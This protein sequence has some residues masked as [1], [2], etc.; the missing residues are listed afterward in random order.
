MDLSLRDGCRLRVRVIGRGKPVILLHGFGLNANQWLPHA[1]SCSTSHSFIIPDSRGHGTSKFRLGQESSP[2]ET[3]VCDLDEIIKQLDVRDFKLCGYSMGAIVGLAYT[4]TVRNPHQNS[5]LHIE[6][7]PKFH[8]D[9]DWSYGFNPQAIAKAVELLHLL[10]QEVDLGSSLHD[11]PK[12]FVRAYRE[13][14]WLLARIAFPPGLMRRLMQG[15]PDLLCQPWLPDWQ[16]T[17]RLFRW[18]LDEGFDLTSHLPEIPIPVHLVAAKQS[19]YFPVQSIKY[20]RERIKHSK[21]TVFHESGHGLMVSEPIKF[22]RTFR[23]FVRA[24]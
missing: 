20:M 2:L 4:S 5:Y 15:A 6:A 3:M 10:P 22:V 23:Q 8:S 12:S 24:K 9:E 17:H 14:V 18:L 13:F 19:E 7:G 11:M 1:L 21:L 16:F